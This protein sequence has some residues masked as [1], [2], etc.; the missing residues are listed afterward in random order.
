MLTIHDNEIISYVV[1]LKK[2]KIVLHTVQYPSQ[3]LIDIVFDD[4]LAHLFETQL[5]DSIILDITKYELHHFSRE[6]RE[7]LEKQKNYCWP[8]DYHTIEELID[9]L[10]KEQYGFYVLSSSYGLNGWVLAKEYKVVSCK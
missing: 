2:H 1:N 6:N 8:M 10:V 4:V 5:E 9:K 7:L 3:T